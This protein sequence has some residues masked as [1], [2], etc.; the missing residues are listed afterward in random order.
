[1]GGNRIKNTYIVFIG[2]YIEKLYELESGEY[3]ATSVFE[4]GLVEI[5]Y[6]YAQ[7]LIE[8]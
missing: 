5:D 8:D 3:Y 4:D 6:E 2:A 1:M 7:G